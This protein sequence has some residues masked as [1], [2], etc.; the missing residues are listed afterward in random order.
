MNT[1]IER[2]VATANLTPH[3]ELR[4]LL[5]EA[6]TAIRDRPEPWVKVDADRRDA[7]WAHAVSG[8]SPTD[9]LSSS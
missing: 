7:A 8:A 4:E 1:L 3:K 6:A 5:L 9:Q 2:L